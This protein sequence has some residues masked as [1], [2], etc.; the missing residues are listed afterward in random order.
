[1]IATAQPGWRQDR[2]HLALGISLALHLAAV[3]LFNALPHGG[4]SMPR[5]AAAAPGGAP[6]RALLRGTQAQ[7][8]PD[9][10]KQAPSEHRSTDQ[11]ERSAFPARNEG[12]I[13]TSRHPS[14]VPASGE[15][16]HTTVERR[17]VVH[18]PRN[19]YYQI[20]DLDIR[21]WIA[22]HVE[23]DYPEAAARRFMSGKVLIRLFINEQGGID[24][25]IVERADPPGFF[26]VN[27]QSAFNAARYTP[28]VKLG[29][30]VK[31]QLLIEVTF[32]S[33][34]PPKIVEMP[35]R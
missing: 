29:K 9:T 15:E 10:R 13:E 6:V 34:G 27:T 1:M 3:I 35:G 7:A 22:V 17:T 5:T 25:T 24:R 33:V 16:V 31:S 14:H 21:P 20:F 30:A 2:L 28:G 26:E 4:A 18:A 8:E 23:P 32:T 19:S 12:H 11:G